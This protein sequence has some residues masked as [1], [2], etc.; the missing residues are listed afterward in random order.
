MTEYFAFLL[1]LGFFGILFSI[2]YEKIW[3]AIMFG[4]LII[5]GFAFSFYSMERE[6]SA[7]HEAFEGAVSSYGQLPAT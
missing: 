4:I 3:L 6:Q 5:S 1:V 7:F 2:L